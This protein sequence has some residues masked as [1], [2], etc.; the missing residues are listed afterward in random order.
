MNKQQIEL[1][2]LLRQGAKMVREL[3]SLR[4]ID[5]RLAERLAKDY[6]EA[7]PS[8]APQHIRINYT[9]VTAA[10]GSMLSNCLADARALAIETHANVQLTHNGSVYWV[11]LNPVSGTVC[12]DGVEIEA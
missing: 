12:C 6:E 10:L 4:R 7:L 2:H 8:L 3:K 9:A 11:Q 5:S 1:A